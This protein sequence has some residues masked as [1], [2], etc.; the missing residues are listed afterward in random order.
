MRRFWS[1]RVGAFAVAI[2]ALGSG[3]GSTASTGTSGT[4]ATVTHDRKPPPTAPVRHSATIHFA[5]GRQSAALT[6]AEP[7]GVILL[8]RISAPVGAR[9][10]GTTQLPSTSA[11]LLIG[12]SRV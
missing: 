11:P 9:I 8:Y 4:H 6:M 10:R 7:D 2:V 1:C 3:C 5:G 12:T